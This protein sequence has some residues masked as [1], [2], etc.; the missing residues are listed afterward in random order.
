M[1]FRDW[2]RRKPAPAPVA[3]RK[4]Y[5]F[6]GAQQNR[7]LED[8]VATWMSPK[9]ELRWELQLLRNRAREQA[10]NNPLARRYFALV[11][12]N[13]LGPEGIS[14]Q[15]KYVLR[16]GEPDEETCAQVERAW[17]DWCRLGHC[18]ADGGQSWRDFT[19]AVLEAVARDG[20]GVVELLPGFGNDH[21][22]AVQFHEGDLIDHEYN[23]DALPG[24]ASI[25]MGIERDRWR[26]IVAVH[27]L[28]RH[29]ADGAV[30][31]SGRRE[32][33]RIAAER[34]LYLGRPRRHGSPRAEPWLTPVLVPM[35]MLDEYQNAEL[36]AAR[37][38]AETPAFITKNLEATG[39]DPNDP[40]AGERILDTAKGTLQELGPGEGLATWP[41]DHP[42]QNV[43]PFLKAMQ[44]QIAVGLGVSYAA[45]TG[46]LSGANYS[47][48]RVGSLQERDNWRVLQRWFSQA[49]HQRVFAA[50]LKQ[51]V[52]WQRVRLPGPLAEYTDVTWQARGFPWVDL[53]A[54]LDA[55]RLEV[56]MGLNSLTKLAADR[57]RDFREVLLERKRE[58]QIAK[59]LGV[60]VTLDVPAEIAST[61]TMTDGNAAPKP[62]APASPDDAED[63][64][65]DPAEERQIVVNVTTPPVNVTVERQG[66][67]AVH[68]AA[69]VV[70]VERQEAPVVHVAPA[71]VSVTV[72]GA[73]PG[74][75]TVRH[76][77]D[78]DGKIVASEVEERAE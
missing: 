22:F 18:T 4:R 33:R 48:M 27:V 54:E 58:E 56:R 50:W 45:L 17:S 67:E 14:L 47:S 13:V 3:P 68:V 43:D 6:A 72:E 60:T 77:R 52:I 53:S 5:A 61:S 34:A 12:E 78:A 8:W 62:D 46:D 10:R 41:S 28:T 21:G 31:A 32:R 19:G 39:P 38:A 40:L 15:C 76:V 65:E 64:T 71:E 73:K 44:R 55:A 51:A 16:S 37:A 42:H 26:R 9:D 20:D 75:R 57:G 70:T 11:D 30:L 23:V 24:G 36:V 74:K 59:E 29:P 7:L 69:P 35:R 25:A 49:L 1:G 66:P 2:F 63:T